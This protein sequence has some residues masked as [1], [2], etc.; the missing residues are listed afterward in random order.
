MDGKWETFDDKGKL[1]NT[2]IYKNDKEIK[3]TGN[4]KDFPGYVDFY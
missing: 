3:C 4:C 1:V 2:R